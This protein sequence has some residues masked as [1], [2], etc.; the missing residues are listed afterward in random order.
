MDFK[1]GDRIRVIKTIGKATSE[2]YY[3][4]YTGYG[5]KVGHT[6]TIKCIRKGFV[7]SYGVEFDD[8]VKGHSCD[9]YIPSNNGL[10]VGSDIIELMHL[11]PRQRIKRELLEA[12]ENV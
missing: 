10:F 12:K 5:V 8:K 3:Y 2:Q 7:L 9:G 4:D 11:T 1:V 6:G